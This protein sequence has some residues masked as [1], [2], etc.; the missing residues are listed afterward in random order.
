[1]DDSPNTSNFKRLSRE[2]F[3][4]IEVFA[5]DL[6]SLFKTSNKTQNKLGK[7][8]EYNQN[9]ETQTEEVLKE[10]ISILSEITELM[11]QLLEQFKV[12]KNDFNKVLKKDNNSLLSLLS[13]AGFA[14]IPPNIQR[15]DLEES[16]DS[17]APVD[18]PDSQPIEP[19]P[20]TVESPAPAT[21]PSPDATPA[22]APDIPDRVDGYEDRATSQAPP[23]EGD[24]RVLGTYGR[25]EKALI[26]TPEGRSMISLGETIPGTGLVIKE[27]TDEG[28]IFN[29]FEGNPVGVGGVLP[30]TGRPAEPITPTSE[31]QTL[32]TGTETGSMLPRVDPEV[33]EPTTTPETIPLEQTDSPYSPPMEF[34]NP[35]N[36]TPEPLITPTI[37]TDPQEP[38]PENQI[39]DILPE[40]QTTKP[41]MD[42]SVSGSSKFG[43][44]QKPEVTKFN[45]VLSAPNIEPL[46]ISGNISPIELEPTP[47]I[48]YSDNSLTPMEET[49]RTPET[50]T[51]GD[52]SS[53]P[54]S[55]GSNPREIPRRNTQIPESFT[56]WIEDLRFKGEDKENTDE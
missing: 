7:I 55:N 46:D 15:E 17:D 37:D 12:F 10:S 13:M 33:T 41:V 20:E 56:N 49:Q 11:K 51:G 54:N 40:E 31:R 50:D 47:S 23:E 39:L 5:K 38:Q 25:G 34:P 4:S 43:D 45:Q 26:Q 44:L 2:Y 35:T 14:M 30:G 19:S 32:D 3:S 6:H 52:R 53:T 42:K 8:S 1:M 36:V 21:Q 18:A 48:E 24:Y 27:I 16:P 29:G 28:V 22:P 9:K